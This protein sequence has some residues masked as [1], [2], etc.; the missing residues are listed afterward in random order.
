M[1]LGDVKFLPVLR[2]TPP[3]FAFPSWAP[4]DLVDRFRKEWPISKLPKGA[5]GPFASGDFGRDLLGVLLSSPDM[6]PVWKGLAKRKRLIAAG[7]KFR[8]TDTWALYAACETALLR[9]AALPKRTR[10]QERAF[11]RRIDAVAKELAALIAESRNNELLRIQRFFQPDWAHSLGELFELDMKDADDYAKF[12]I[13]DRF[14]DSVELLESLAAYAEA[15]ALKPTGAPQP[16]ADSA[17]AIYFARAI[18]GYFRRSYGQPLH[19]HVAAVTHA[20]FGLPMDADR[21]RKLVRE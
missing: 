14:P 1:F 18:S 10:S 15:R 7:K 8:P 21:I 2:K 5:V 19:E 3:T 17:A 20:V 4:A 16:K 11:Y 6:K 12:W 13:T 9:W